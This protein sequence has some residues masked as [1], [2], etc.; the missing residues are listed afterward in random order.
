MLG[1]SRL[2]PTRS[3]FSH[4]TT[5]M[6]NQRL[7]CRHICRE[8]SS[9]G[10]EFCLQNRH[11]GL[12]WWAGLAEF[13]GKR[14]I[15]VYVNVNSRRFYFD[16]LILPPTLNTQCTITYFAT[17]YPERVIEA[18]EPQSMNPNRC[19]YDSKHGSRVKPGM[20]DQI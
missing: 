13:L 12:S 19:T 16:A 6:V 20:T 1:P 8:V 9:A 2:T 4:L 7:H 14:L 5:Q 15:D 18:F 11:A 3:R 17:Q 10:V